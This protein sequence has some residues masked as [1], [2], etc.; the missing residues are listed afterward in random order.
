MFVAELFVYRSLMPA[1]ADAVYAWHARP[2]ALTKLTPP[3][4]SAR[5]VERTGGIEQP[6]SRV[7]IQLRI[8]PLKQTWTAEHTEY[9]PGRMFRDVM[10]SG[11]FRS[12]Q[13]THLFIPE[14]ASSSWLEDR[15]KYEFPLSWF[16]RI[17]GG[18][19]TRRRLTRMFAWRHRVTQEALQ[20][21]NSSS[22]SW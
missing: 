14:T 18:A 3:W 16:G 21:E 12:W 19:Y 6:G 7:K 22:T 2:D 15:V 8:G 9:Q 11:P 5:V 20:R 17:V 13:H 1:S 10:V 4:E